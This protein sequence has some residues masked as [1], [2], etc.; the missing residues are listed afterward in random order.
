ML[1]SSYLD[2][3]WRLSARFVTGEDPIVRSRRHAIPTVMLPHP[4]SPLRSIFSSRPPSKVPR[5]P[6]SPKLGFSTSIPSPPQPRPKSYHP[7]LNHPPPSPIT[8]KKNAF[9]VQRSA[10]L[11][12]S[13]S[14]PSNLNHM[15]LSTSNTTLIENRGQ[16][17]HGGISMSATHTLPSLCVKFA[18]FPLV[19]TR[20]SSGRGSPLMKRVIT[21]M[22]RS[23]EAR[24][25]TSIPASYS[26]P[27]L[28][29][30]EE[31]S[32]YGSIPPHRKLR[33][34]RRD[35]PSPI[36][37]SH[38]TAVNSDGTVTSLD[39]SE[40]LASDNESREASSIIY[41]ALALAEPYL[42]THG[43]STA[44][45]LNPASLTRRLGR[46]A[47]E[48]RTPTLSSPFSPTSPIP[49]RSILASQRD[50]DALSGPWLFENT[51]G[52][53]SGE[54]LASHMLGRCWSDSTA[55][56]RE[57]EH[58]PTSSSTSSALTVDAPDVPTNSPVP[59]SIRSSGASWGTASSSSFARWDSHSQKASFP[60]LAICVRSI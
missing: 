34:P 8:A 50:F 57:S 26:M 55:S 47:M 29:S 20:P 13:V 12:V 41:S 33:K 15:S 3:L 39:T 30:A 35:L 32:G 4:S 27:R 19:S 42:E 11:P 53:L 1:D 51:L 6:R 58:D 16:P 45:N 25:P 54:S 28:Y 40:S 49:D 10:S 46:L 14:L 5:S 7:L 59:P 56:V 48:T 21:P 60:L 43:L 44:H 22:P 23:Y 24:N 9:L 2:P 18:P 36:S 37:T 52:S 31:S 17:D 38:S